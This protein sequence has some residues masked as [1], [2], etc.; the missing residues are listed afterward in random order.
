MNELK[1]SEATRYMDADS[2]LAKKWESL[3]P[4]VQRQFLVATN[5]YPLLRAYPAGGLRQW[6]ACTVLSAILR[7]KN[8]DSLEVQEYLAVNFPR[9]PNLWRACVPQELVER[10]DQGDF[11]IFPFS[12][13]L[14]GGGEEEA[15]KTPDNEGAPA[16]GGGLEIPL[17]EKTDDELVELLGGAL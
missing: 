7:G 6:I 17:S 9:L 8:V 16:A 5:V 3:A 14:A 4:S 11:S 15:A 10:I 1:I 13:A 2:V 12:D